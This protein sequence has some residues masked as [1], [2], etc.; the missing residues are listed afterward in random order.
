MNNFLKI[1]FVT[2]LSACGG[3]EEG[4]CN[5]GSYAGGKLEG[6]YCE[7][8]EMRFTELRTRLQSSGQQQFLAIEYVRPLGTGL[9]KTLSVVLQI[10]SVTV[11]PGQPID[12][13]AAGGSVRRTLSEGVMNLT[14]EVENTST[15]TLDVDQGEVN[16]AIKGRVNILF[17][18]GRTL[19]GEF[20][21]NLTA[22]TPEG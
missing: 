9:E 5:G 11:T 7:D 19:S 20:D 13:L 17:K 15:L 12:L 4:V 14:P 16:T 21:G 3:E 10:S 18:T 22:T 1:L 6:S 2:T 8:V